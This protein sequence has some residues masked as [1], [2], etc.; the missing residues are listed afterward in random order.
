[1]LDWTL[2]FDARGPTVATHRSVFSTN[3]CTPT[4]SVAST[5]AIDDRVIRTQT[6]STCSPLR[7]FPEVVT[8][9]ASWTRLGSLIRLAAGL[10]YLVRL[11]WASPRRPWLWRHQLREPH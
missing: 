2:G 11:Q 4:A 3:C 10:L 9:A 7:V 5:T 8:A 6:S 1:M